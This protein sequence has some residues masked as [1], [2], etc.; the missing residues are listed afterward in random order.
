MKI[1]LKS[2]FIKA[3]IKPLVL[4]VFLSTIGVLIMRFI[5]INSWFVLIAISLGIVIIYFALVFLIVLTNDEKRKVFS[6]IK[7]RKVKK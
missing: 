2:F 1:D 4:V 6:F 7:E 5:S 3:Y